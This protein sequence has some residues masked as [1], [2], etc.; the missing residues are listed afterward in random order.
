VN[1]APQTGTHPSAQEN[2]G[3][4]E[5]WRDGFFSLMFTQFQGAFSDNA[6]KWLVTFLVFSANLPKSEQDS[7]VSLAGALFAVPF[8]VFS[9]WGGWLA[10]RCSKR[11]VMMGVKVAEI[12]IMLFAALALARGSLA[13]QL[14][15]IC[16][17]GVHSA[18]F[19]PAKYGILPEILPAARLS[20]GNGILELLTFVA[21]ILGTVTGG[22]LAEAMHGRQAWSGVLLGGLAVVGLLASRG[23]QRVP[24]ADPGKRFTANF[25]A[26]IWRLMGKLRRD[27]DLWRAN[28]GN[29]GFFYIA[30]LVQMNL[31][32]FA[33]QVFELQPTQQSWLQ[34]ALCL[35]IGAGS[36]CA[37]QL[38]R[39]RIAYGFIPIGAVVMAAAAGVMGWPGIGRS[40]F[41]TA[42]AL[43]GFGGGL[44]IVPVAAVL[45]HRPAATEKGAVQGIAS[46]LSWVGIIAAAAT[47]EALGK[48]FHFTH[49]QV[50]WFCGAAALVAGLYVA[51]TRPGAIRA[52]FAPAGAGDGH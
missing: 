50:F 16:L 36:A 41:T 18:F 22:W 30:A 2:P 20:W 1:D 4:R 6:L 21:I 43:L 14:T 28:W 37:G 45:Q 49:A 34:A 33:K 51:R 9:M 11:T 24:A 5:R 8:L 7:I 39:G 52:L 35:G 19:A 29:T 31:A 42:L 17:M 44:F 46:W 25:P 26:E 27:T 13:L 47:Q 15:A 48:L 38:S 23:I 32:L 10:D 3:S 12:G 40:S